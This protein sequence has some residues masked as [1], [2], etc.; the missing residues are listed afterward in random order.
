MVGMGRGAAGGEAQIV[1]RD[2][3]V[4]IAAADAARGFR[5]DTAGTHRADAAANALFAEFAM[6]SLIFHALLPGIRANFFAVFKQSVGC[7]FHLFDRDEGG[8]HFAQCYF[9]P[10]LL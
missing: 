2:D 3:A 6:R 9:L 5:S 1:A 8:I 7:R 4:R 10:N